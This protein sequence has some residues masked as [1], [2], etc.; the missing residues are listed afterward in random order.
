MDLGLK[1]NG[2]MVFILAHCEYIWKV[3]CKY[4]CWPNKVGLISMEVGI[5][6][7]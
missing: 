2:P 5:E 4:D 3:S 1:Y 7:G 6:R